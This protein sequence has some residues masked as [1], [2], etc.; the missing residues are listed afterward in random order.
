M[1]DRYSDSF[2][3]ETLKTTQLISNVCAQLVGIF[4]LLKASKV[5]CHD[6]GKG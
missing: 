1:G 2:K 6:W 5:N 3:L 4:L